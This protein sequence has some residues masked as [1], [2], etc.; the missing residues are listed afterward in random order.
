M[1][2]PFDVLNPPN[3]FDGPRFDP[4]SPFDHL[5][6]PFRDRMSFEL[7]NRVPDRAALDY[8]GANLVGQYD[9]TRQKVCRCPLRMSGY[10]NADCPKND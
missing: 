5:N 6:P 10:H 3:I 4:P 7:T 2:N 9:R 1:P 8:A